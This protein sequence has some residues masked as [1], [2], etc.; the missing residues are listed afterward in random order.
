LVEQRDD[1]ADLVGAFGLVVGA[2]LQTDFF[3]V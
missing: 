2:G 1:G 3:W